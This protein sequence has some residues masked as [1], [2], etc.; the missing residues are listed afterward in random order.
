[1]KR[2]FEEQLCPKC[3]EY[4]V[5]SIVK[6]DRRGKEWDESCN[7]DECDFE[8]SDFYINEDDEYDYR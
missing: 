6:S 8:E 2:T 7:N 5:T 3:G 1:M 4:T